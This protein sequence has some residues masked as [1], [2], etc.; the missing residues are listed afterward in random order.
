MAKS[1]VAHN[2]SVN[3]MKLLSNGGLI[4][5]SSDMTLA[6]W[7]FSTHSI[8]STFR[9]HT[10]QVN[11]FDVL[12]NG[13][14]A[15]AGD[16]KNIF[17]WNYT[18]GGLVNSKSMA[19][20]GSILCIKALP[21]GFFASASGSPD[22]L[23]KIWDP[24]NLTQPIMSLSG[25]TNDILS[26]EILSNGNLISGSADGYSIVWDLNN[27]NQTNK[28]QPLT[29]QKVSCIKELPDGTIAFGG[30]SP[31][32]YIWR[33]NGI[34]SESQVSMGLNILSGEQPCHAFLLYNSTMLAVASNTTKTE[35]LNIG[36]TSNIFYIKSLALG[37]SLTLTLEN[38]CN[39]KT[40]TFLLD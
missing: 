38:E 34:N 32:I 3:Y 27:G 16:D 22:N 7:N 25:H 5:A 33:I 18:N 23:I 10:A 12:N 29:L 8:L 9:G 11:S 31:S 20:S 30:D 24:E 14:V 28:F 19:H 26:L 6:V 15:S 21:N 39:I 36:N 2:K 13:L 1:W 40:F 35:L 4:S 37:A 17:V